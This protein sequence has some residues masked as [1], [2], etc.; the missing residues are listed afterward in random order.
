MLRIRRYADPDM[1]SIATVYRQAVLGIDEQ[2]Y[3][4]LQLQMWASMANNISA[5]AETLDQG[6]T[7][8]AEDRGLIC[9]FGQ[10]HPQHRISLLYV[11]PPYFRRG[12]AGKIYHQLEQQAFAENVFEI[13]TEA[14]KVSRPFFLKRGFEVIE[15]QIVYINSVP[16][17]RFKMRKI[18]ACETQSCNN[19]L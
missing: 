5:F 17:E 13:S 18:Y 14:S 8:V 4:P 9:A 15:P 12:L 3:S 2:F 10:L 1:K 19:L 7:L 16:I 6:Y 11:S